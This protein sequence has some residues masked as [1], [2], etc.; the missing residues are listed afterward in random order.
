MRRI[1]TI[2]TIFAFLIVPQVSSA[3]DVDDLRAAQEKSIEAW[4][5]LDVLNLLSLV[6]PTGAVL[7][8]HDSAFPS[9]SAPADMTR[10][11]RE[12]MAKT[13]FNDVEYISLTPYNLQYKVVGNTGI[14][15]G[16][17]SMSI[18][19]KGEPAR[20]QFSRFTSTWI[21]SDGKWL[22]LSMHESAIPTGN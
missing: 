13:A 16:H 1:L 11:Q 15:W 21:K 2:I 14:V 20:T 5:K 9:I 19:P 4:N 17:S 3:D 8:E 18:K 10:E 6:Y 7:F 12:A 22:L